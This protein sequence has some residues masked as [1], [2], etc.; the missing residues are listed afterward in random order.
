MKPLTLVCLTLLLGMAGCAA[1][2]ACHVEAS[3]E[4][5]EVRMLDGVIVTS[6]V[7]G[8]VY[9][10][11]ADEWLESNEPR[12]AVWRYPTG[13]L[14]ELRVD[15]QSGRVAVSL[16]EGRYCFRASAHGFNATVGRIE[17]R[18]SAPARVLDVRLSVAN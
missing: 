4:Q 7:A 17:V 16:P 6:Q 15:T 1:P 12:F 14:T 13:E 11:G 18:R 5:F 3:P 8:T 10:V 2:W 9:P